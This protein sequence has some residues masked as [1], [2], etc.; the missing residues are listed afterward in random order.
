MPGRGRFVDLASLVEHDPVE[1]LCA[2]LGYEAEQKVAAHIINRTLMR[3]AN[4]STC[5]AF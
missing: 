1:F 5:I 4:L 3:V 2:L